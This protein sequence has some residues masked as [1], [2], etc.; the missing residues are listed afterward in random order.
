M[1]LTFTNGK[2]GLLGLIESIGDFSPHLSFSPSKTIRVSSRTGFVHSVLVVHNGPIIVL[3]RGDKNKNDLTLPGYMGPF[4]ATFSP[5]HSN[6]QR[7]Q[8]K[9]LSFLY[10]TMREFHSAASKSFFLISV[11][12]FVEEK[13]GMPFKNWLLNTSLKPGEYC[14]ILRFLVHA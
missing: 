12:L 9:T 10:T 11:V 8:L 14:V 3:E 2:N 13:G 4:A 5:L 1:G 6:L 7:R